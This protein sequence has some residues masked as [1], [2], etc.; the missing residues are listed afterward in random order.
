MTYQEVDEKHLT[1]Q[2]SNFEAFKQ[3]ADRYITEFEENNLLLAAINNGSLTKQNYFDLLNTIFHQVYMGSSSFAL[4]GA[5]V[6][7]RYFKVREYLFHHAEEEQDH[8][9][10]IIQNLYDSGYS[11]PDPRENFPKVKTQA[12]ISFAM[13]LAQKQPVARLAMGYILE[14]ISGRLGIDYGLKAAKQL[15]LSKEQMSFFVLHGELDQGHSND[16]LEVLKLTPLSPYEWAYCDYA[17]KCTSEL[18][19]EMYNSSL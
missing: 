10:W 1:Y 4:A 17:A 12:Y 7:S 19:L 3:N 16:I 9:K 6:D 5:M 18:Y 13:Y 11:G 14:G 15:N 8:W 2:T